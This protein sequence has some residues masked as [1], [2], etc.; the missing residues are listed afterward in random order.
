MANSYKPFSK[1]EVEKRRKKLALDWSVTPKATQL[2]RDFTFPDYLDAFMFVARTTVHAE[3]MKHHP[4]LTLS[5]GKV[6]VKTTTH[7]A[8]GLTKL[9]FDL[10]K[11]V[12]NVYARVVAKRG[13]G[14]YR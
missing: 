5:Y 2:K 9:D 10:A 13:A 8:K 7:D 6:T 3:I 1:T 12:E 11:K 14:H 4:E